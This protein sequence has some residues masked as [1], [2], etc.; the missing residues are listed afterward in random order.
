M[1]FFVS[2]RNR[3][4]GN[5]KP[6]NP[7]INSSADGVLRCASQIEVILF[8]DYE[9]REPHVIAVGPAVML[10]VSIYLMLIAI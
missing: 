10:Q 6:E 7:S 8:E 5:P 3:K 2:W 4:T 1:C 9:N